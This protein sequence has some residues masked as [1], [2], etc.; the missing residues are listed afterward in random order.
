MT[1]F[2]FPWGARCRALHRE[3]AVPVSAGLLCS[4]QTALSAAQDGPFGMASSPAPPASSAPAGCCVC[5]DAQ[6]APSD[7][8]CAAAS[9]RISQPLWVVD[10]SFRAFKRE[11]G[12]A[13]ISCGFWP[14]DGFP[15]SVPR[16]VKCIS[17]EKQSPIAASLETGV[18]LSEDFTIL[19]PEGSDWTPPF[20]ML[21]FIPKEQTFLPG[22]F[23]I[24]PGYSSQQGTKGH[25]PYPG[26]S[27]LATSPKCPRRPY[28]FVQDQGNNVTF[29]FKICPFC[30]EILVLSIMSERCSYTP[31]PHFHMWNKDIRSCPSVVSVEK[32][33]KQ[34]ALTDANIW[35]GRMII[36][37]HEEKIHMVKLQ[38]EFY[39]ERWIIDVWE[40]QGRSFS[41]V[42]TMH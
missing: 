28:G 12:N 14:K 25:S 26:D 27:S 42:L 2:I 18:Q 3:E 22:L 36:H 10:I 16:G 23:L 5:Q 30:W 17:H 34:E 11:V 20:F 35:P 41:S 33:S 1:V 21:L 38:E 40:S 6:Q 29:T 24:L 15:H 19:R 37:E 13:P 39:L 7:R 9:S 31:M 32:R 8:W 4:S